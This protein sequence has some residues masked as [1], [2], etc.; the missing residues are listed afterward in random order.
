M[1]E[2]EDFHPALIFSLPLLLELEK[3]LGISTH[4]ECVSLCSKNI[5]CKSA[6]IR[7]T[8]CYL[9]KVGMDNGR[10]K[11]MSG[12][13]LYVMSHPDYVFEDI[14]IKSLN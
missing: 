5:D 8:T 6:G 11:S 12:M 14:L 4:D 3:Y 7:E 2:L 13:K 1:S 9:Y 10:F